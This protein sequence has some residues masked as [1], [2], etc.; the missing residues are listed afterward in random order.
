MHYL[1]KNLFL[2]F[3]ITVT[4]SSKSMEQN[5]IASSKQVIAIP[6]GH[7]INRSIEIILSLYRIIEGQADMEFEEPKNISRYSWRPD[8]FNTKKFSLPLLAKSNSSLKISGEDMRNYF[9]RA[10]DDNFFLLGDS[11]CFGGIR[12]FEA[13]INALKTKLADPEQVNNHVRLGILAEILK[14][15]KIEPI[16]DKILISEL[17]QEIAKKWQFLELQGYLSE[18][19][20]ICDNSSKS[21]VT[22]L[23]SVKN[24]ITETKTA[25]TPSSVSLTKPTPS[26]EENK[27]TQTHKPVVADSTAS[28]DTTLQPQPVTISTPEPT[29]PTEENKN[30]QTH[31]PVVADSTAS[32]DTTLQLQPSTIA[33]SVLPVLPKSATQITKPIT[34]NNSLAQ[35][36]LLNPGD[37]QTDTYKQLNGTPK[38]LFKF[39][40][41]R[42]LLGFGIALILC[43]ILKTRILPLIK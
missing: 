36:S 42:L 27:N 31:K 1:K 38:S 32:I 5:T 28:I 39:S 7:E 24:P 18:I 35:D 9:K 23:E 41:K 33:A 16:D 6:N 19:Y 14:Q 21:E 3:A 30:T 17:K 13:E 26:T 4:F 12:C 34:K 20:E 25:P 29:P 15:I 2:L 37:L 11:R 10:P 40:Y 8:K 43:I 22:S